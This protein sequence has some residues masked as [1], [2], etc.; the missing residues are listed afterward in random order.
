M[1]I[2]DVDLVVPDGAAL[3][4]GLARSLADRLGAVL[5]APPGRVWVRL[6]ALAATRYAENDVAVGADEL[7]VFVTILHAHPPE[8]EARAR[9]AS[10]IASEVAS[11]LG[12]NA[13][14]VHVEY[15]PAGAGRV[16][17]GG[18]LVT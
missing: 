16:A 11:V 1:P 6:H 8:G 17:F 2:L 13:E 7:P 4:S 3:P 15:A 5:Q 9:E 10:A 14:R 12:R 18:K